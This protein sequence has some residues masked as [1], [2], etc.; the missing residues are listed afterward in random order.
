M[1]VVL[2]F[3]DDTRGIANVGVTAKLGKGASSFSAHD[4]F[5]H[6]GLTLQRFFSGNYAD[7]LCKGK[8]QGNCGPE[9]RAEVLSFARYLLKLETE[10][11]VHARAIALLDGIM[12]GRPRATA[13]VVAGRERT[14]CCA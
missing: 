1:R 9:G 5:P 11:T 2:G 14:R 12:L 4:K 10:R 3:E 8:G 7:N 13:V 6:G